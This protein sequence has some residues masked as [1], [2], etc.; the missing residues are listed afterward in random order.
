MPPHSFSPPLP[1]AKPQN[2]ASSS[3]PAHVVLQEQKHLLV[4][5]Q[6]SKLKTTLLTR[7]GTV[8]R[9][10]HWSGF[11]SIVLFALQTSISEAAEVFTI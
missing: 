10:I 9:G 11:E 5:L 4:I 6:S 8:I 7:Q 3:A 1:H 2:R